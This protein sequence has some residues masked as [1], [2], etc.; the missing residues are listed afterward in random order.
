MRKAWT[1]VRWLIE[2]YK[3]DIKLMLL[4]ATAVVVGLM[5]YAQEQ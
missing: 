5:T 1:R 2:F 3:D 4:F